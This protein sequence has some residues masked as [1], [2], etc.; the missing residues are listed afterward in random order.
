MVQLIGID[1]E[2]DVLTRLFS[3]SHVRV[4]VFEQY[5]QSTFVVRRHFAYVRCENG[6]QIVALICRLHSLEEPITNLIHLGIEMRHGCT[7][8]RIPRAVQRLRY[9]F[10]SQIGQEQVD[11]VDMVNL[12][13]NLWHTLQKGRRAVVVQQV[14][15]DTVRAAHTQ[16]LTKCQ[17]IQPVANH[18]E[19]HRP[20]VRCLQIASRHLQNERHGTGH[21]CHNTTTPL[22]TAA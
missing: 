21:S 5:A 12:R 17:A 11:V 3:E 20:R 9:V 22:D 15:V 18:I 2:N 8:A 10:V 7:S 14:E 13:Q 4:H 19:H 6:R 1:E 16:S